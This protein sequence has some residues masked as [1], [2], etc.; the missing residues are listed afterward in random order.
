V[1]AAALAMAAAALAMAAASSHRAV[2]GADTVV[3]ATAE[4]A[5]VQ[6]VAMGTVVAAA[7]AAR[8][9]EATAAT[10]LACRSRGNLFRTHT[11]R[12]R[13]RRR[14]RRRCH[15]Q[16][17]SRC[18]N[19]SLAP[20]A[21]A[22]VATAV[23]VVVVGLVAAWVGKEGERA[24]VAWAAA[25]MAM[26]VALE[27]HTRANRSPSNRRP[28]RRLPSPNAGRRRRRRHRTQTGSCWSTSLGSA[29]EEAEMETVAEAAV[30]AAVAGL[31][32]CGQESQAGSQATEARVEVVAE[33]E[34]AME[35]A[36]LRR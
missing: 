35:Q 27:T 3:V 16:D 9:V 7:V 8:E 15:R 30:K 21:A 11:R 4:G 17:R 5:E 20:R 26:G 31:E 25:V 23:R 36:P 6:E 33:S 1:T 22:K 19:T 28:A 18:W 29:A 13:T 24:E 12:I 14:H 34:E 10:Y 2:R 32:A